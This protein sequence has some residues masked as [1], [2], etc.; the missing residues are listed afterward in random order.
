MNGEVVEE[1]QIGLIIGM[2]FVWVGLFF[3][4]SLV[5]SIFMPNDTFESVTMVVASSLGNTGPT[6]GDFGPANT[7]A[8]MNSGALIITSILM[9]FG[10]L[11]LLTAVILL[12]PHTWRREDKSDGELQGLALVKR[13]LQEKEE[14]N[15]K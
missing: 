1:K 3:I 15:S 4:S 9:W 5:L 6:L 11:E 8:S 10:R 2:L 7:W 13:I 14:P 12:H